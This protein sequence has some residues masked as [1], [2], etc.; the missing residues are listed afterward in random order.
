MKVMKIFS[1]IL[2]ITILCA[3]INLVFD[4]AECEA[5]L[6]GTTLY[7]DDNYTPATGGWG[8]SRFAKIQDA[9]DNAS[10]GDSIIVAN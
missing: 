6:A 1:S 9:V 4:N 10:A 5:P 8:V 2:V 3:G 7:V